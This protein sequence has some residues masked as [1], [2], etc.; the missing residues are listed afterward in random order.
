MNF[1]FLEL[2]ITIALLLRNFTMELI[3]GQNEKVVQSLI[4][5]PKDDLKI[6][7][8]PRNV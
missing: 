4:L 3:P 1:A 6:R 7:F 5:R 2:K 8:V